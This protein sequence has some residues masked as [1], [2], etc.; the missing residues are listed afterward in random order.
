MMKR[1]TLLFLGSTGAG[2]VYSLEMAKALS[3]TGECQLHCV[4]SERISNL[5]DWINAF[6]DSDVL[7]DIVETYNHNKLSFVLSTLAFGK[8]SKICRLIRGFQ[9]EILYVPFLLTWDFLIYPK[10]YKKMRIVATLH[11]PHPHDTSRNPFSNWIHKQNKKAYNYVSDVII[12]N[13]CDIQYV[14]ENFC[15]NVHVIPHASFSSYVN[16]VNSSR[17]VKNTMGFLGRIEPYKGLDLLVDAFLQL[18]SKYKLIIAGSGKIDELTY[19]KIKDNDRIELLNRY[20]E[21][22]EFTG[23]LNR[24]DFVVLPYKRASQSGVIPLVFAHGKTVIATNVGALEE[25]VPEGTGMIVEPTV[26]SLVASIT[27]MYSNPTRL[28][29]FGENA[30]IYA[31]SELTW[32]SSAKKVLNII[33]QD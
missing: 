4:I 15:P 10:L 31:D 25:Q 17:E 5:S 33:N 14:R 2:P 16:E 1:V 21:D 26:V 27:D 9:P 12:L 24:M 28:Q 23:L 11:D 29:S 22:N 30:K 20:I 3:A 6:A 13:N 19:E 32:E 7:L 18:D 8:I